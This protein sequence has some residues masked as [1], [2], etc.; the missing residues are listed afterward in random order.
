MNNNRRWLRLY[1]GPVW[2]LPLLLGC[3][4]VTGYVAEKILSGPMALR[5]FVWFAAAAVLHDFVLF[6][7]YSAIDRLVSATQRNLDSARQPVINYF[8]VPA[9]LSVLMLLICL[10]T[11]LGRGSG[12]FHAASGL[13]QTNTFLRWILL[14]VSFFA[15]SG[16]VFVLRLLRFRHST[17]ERP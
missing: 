6:P 17:K 1:G 14:S 7:A 10:P 9:S 12:T 15:V 2:S 4:T 13:G 8:R 11:I 3:L 16:A 5:I